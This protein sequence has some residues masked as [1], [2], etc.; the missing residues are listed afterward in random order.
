MERTP[1]PQ[2][3]PDCLGPAYYDHRNN[4]QRLLLEDPDAQ[5]SMPVLSV[6]PFITMAELTSAFDSYMFETLGQ[7]HGELAYAINERFDE[8]NWK[9]QE[10]PPPGPT[11]PQT[12][13]PPRMESRTESRPQLG[14]EGSRYT[15]QANFQGYSHES[16]AQRRDYPQGGNGERTPYGHQPFAHSSGPSAI[17]TQRVVESQSRYSGRPTGRPVECLRTVTTSATST[18]STGVKAGATRSSHQAPASELQRTAA[19]EALSPRERERDHDREHERPC[20]RSGHETGFNSRL[21]QAGGTSRQRN[22][23]YIRTNWGGKGTVVPWD[24]IGVVYN[25]F[26]RE[27]IKLVVVVAMVME[28]DGVSVSAQSDNSGFS[29]R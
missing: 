12:S 23:L 20:F 7:T 24:A 13:F 25:L 1:D 5:Q 9:S 19:T 16:G 14:D 18:R 6:E 29:C 21:C 2:C 22:I 8:W 28:E 10:G 3:L 11:S 27:W 15:P 26:N 17:S 4:H